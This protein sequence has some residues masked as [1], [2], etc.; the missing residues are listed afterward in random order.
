MS[1]SNADKIRG[2]RNHNAKLTPERVEFIRRMAALTAAIPTQR[3]IAAAFGVST[4]RLRSITRYAA[5]RHL[6]HWTRREMVEE[7]REKFAED[8]RKVGL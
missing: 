5:W 3:E 7:L 2:E 6:K 8:F 1:R 4:F